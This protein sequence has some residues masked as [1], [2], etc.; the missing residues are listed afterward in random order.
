M[1]IPSVS[2]TSH[3]SQF[4]TS[5]RLLACLVTEGL[6]SAYVLPCPSHRS[7][8]VTALCIVVYQHAVRFGL[9]DIHSIVP[10]K[11]LPLVEPSCTDN[12][13]HKVK[14][15]DP[16]DMLPAIYTPC[17]AVVSEVSQKKKFS[18]NAVSKF[19]YLMRSLFR[20]CS[21][22]GKT[23][24]TGRRL[25][26]TLCRLKF[27]ICQNMTSVAVSMAANFGLPLQSRST[28]INN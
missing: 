8:D 23:M 7:S 22:L 14:L 11:N 3:F 17:A 12:G 4:A 25:H 2:R 24:S 10:L 26:T 16:M 19:K 27:L 5:S 9:K 1:P 15:L 6:M 13:L 20:T 18:V 28:W 21:G